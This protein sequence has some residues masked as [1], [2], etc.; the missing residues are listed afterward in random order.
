[1]R[2]RQFIVGLWGAFEW[3]SMTLA[4]GS[5]KL[6]IVGFLN[7]ASAEGYGI[8]AAAFK[9]GLADSG[10]VEP[11]NVIVEYRWANDDYTRLPALAADLVSRRV[12]VIFANSPSITSAQA[13]TK[14]I[15]IVFLSGDDPVRLGVVTSLN[16]PEGNTTGVAILS[17]E[18]AGK[19][20]GL[21]H[22]LV[23]E[24]KK[25]AVLVNSDFG[26]SRRF[27]A[28]VEAGAV[29][30]GLTINLLHANTDTEIVAA[31]ATLA[32]S[33]ADALLVGPGPFLDSRRKL[34]VGRAMQIRIPAA[35]ETR[36]TAVVG[37]LM[38]YGASVE[39]GYRQAGIHAGR[40]LK[41]E[42]T[43][44]LPVLLPTRVELVINLK[45]A[46]ELGLTIPP[47]LLA[48]ADEVIE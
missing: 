35:Y 27:Q 15:P 14:T 34:L 33:S 38:S 47:A 6:P 48:R 37:G 4:Q 7:S 18:L 44:N 43:V 31:F 20:L 23:P 10:Y 28:D 45:A 46:R 11:D 36:A 30:L 24:S 17:R 22:E 42:K 9:A 29:A 12:D 21:L 8:M 25:I 13:A 2:R 26:P 41:G 32:R 39:E 5:G 19:R 16:K 1:M 40:I 3:A